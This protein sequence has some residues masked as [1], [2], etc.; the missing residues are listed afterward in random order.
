[1]SI[2]AVKQFINIK[3]LYVRSYIKCNPYTI[4][5]LCRFLDFK[6]FI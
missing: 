1:M 6:T 2:F 5:Y 3:K 4:S